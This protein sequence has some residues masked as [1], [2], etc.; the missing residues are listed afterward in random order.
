M[1][2]TECLKNVFVSAQWI[3]EFKGPQYIQV[4]QSVDSA[5]SIHSSGGITLA[6][7]DRTLPVALAL[8]KHLNLTE[9][10]ASAVTWPFLDDLQ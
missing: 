10:T 7:H 4:S 5:V 9:D 8:V 2:R 3:K 1:V 6:E